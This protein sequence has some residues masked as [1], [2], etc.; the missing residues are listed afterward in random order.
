MIFLPLVPDS[1]SA[2]AT[3]VGYPLLHMLPL[4]P[5]LGAGIC[6]DALSQLIEGWGV[7]VACVGIEYPLLQTLPSLPL[8][9]ICALS[10]FTEGCAVLAVASDGLSVT[11]SIHVKLHI[12]GMQLLPL[13]SESVLCPA[14]VNS[15]GIF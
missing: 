11:E 5:L 13:F 6:A 7:A 15:N 1:M 12:G 9:V 3:G 4:L 2:D 14:V 10:E 8:L